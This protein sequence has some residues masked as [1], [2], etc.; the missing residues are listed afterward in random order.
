VHWAPWSVQV[1]LFAGFV[2]GQVTQS[3]PPIPQL[4]SVSPYAQSSPMSEHWLL[5]AGSWVGQVAQFQVPN[6]QLHSVEP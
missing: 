5:S 4:Q 6:E 3:Q 2:A 1:S